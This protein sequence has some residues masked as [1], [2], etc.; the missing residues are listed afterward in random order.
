MPF[1]VQELENMANAAM[2][3]Y[4]KGPALA[5]TIQER[6]FL[7]AILA[8]HKTFPG[9]KEFIRRNVKG[10]YVTQIQG[11]SHDDTVTYQ[12]PGRIKQLLA[13]W[14]EIHAG[15]N[16]THT[17]LKHDG[18]SVVDTNGENTSEHSD[19]EVTVITNIL[20][21]KLDDMGEGYSRGMNDMF[22]R[23]G[24]QDAKLVPGVFAIILDSPATGTTFGIDRVANA[25]WRNRASVNIDAS[26]PANQVLVTALQNEIRQVRRY[27]GNPRNWYAGSDFLEALEAELRA[28]GNYTQDGFAKTNRI[29]MSVADLAFKKINIDYDPT[30][31]DLGKSKYSYLLDL[32]HLYPMIMDGED[33]K[34]HSPARPPEKYVVY[35]SMTWTGGLIADQLNCHEVFSIQ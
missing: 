26:V 24:T 30:L 10:E 5:Q 4:V 31:D 13:P 12:N 27:G 6:P 34:Q 23:D 18:I 21:D 9:G 11:Y 29:D 8:V 1:T 20:Q 32:K 33:K 2:D 28:K 17:E 15:I 35:R 14:Y 3:Y 25:W 19:R 16:F 22:W 7:N